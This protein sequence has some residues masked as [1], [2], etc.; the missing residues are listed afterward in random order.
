MRNISISINISRSS[1]INNSISS[2]ISNMK[3]SS[4][5]CKRSLVINIL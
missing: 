4:S 5:I 1:N 2:S 3:S